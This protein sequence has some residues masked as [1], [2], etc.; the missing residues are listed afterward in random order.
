[1]PASARKIK[2]GS[3]GSRL[4]YRAIA[5]AKPAQIASTASICYKKLNEVPNALFVMK[6]IVYDI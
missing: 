2:L 4:E 6:I 5:Y 1:M 3:S